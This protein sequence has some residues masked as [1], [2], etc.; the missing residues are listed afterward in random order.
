MTM[1]MQQQP[2]DRGTHLR[3]FEEMNL[4]LE[5]FLIPL[6]VS[7]ERIDHHNIDSLPYFYHF[8]NTKYVWTCTSLK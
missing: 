5:E 6:S 3:D 8:F 1:E 7:F 2:A 4:V